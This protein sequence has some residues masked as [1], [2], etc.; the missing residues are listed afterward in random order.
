MAD[1]D[2]TLL[3]HYNLP[4]L[5]PLQWPAEKDDSE[6]SQDEVVPPPKASRASQARRSQRPRSVL[7]KLGGS[8][9]SAGFK[10]ESHD[11]GAQVL[12]RRDE[13]DPL[14]SSESVV[15]LLRQRGL[16][17]DHDAKLRT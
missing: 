15:R 5:Y 1:P 7:D 4:S 10:S 9:R 8:R 2:R 6:E 14:G 12:P 13:P 17:V 3:N 11:D 16:P